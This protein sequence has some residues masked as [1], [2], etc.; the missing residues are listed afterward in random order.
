MC[1]SFVAFLSVYIGYFYIQLFAVKATIGSPNFSANFVTLLNVGSIPGRLGSNFI[2]GHIGP[3]N[4]QI[5]VSVLT[6]VMMYAWMGVHNTGGLIVFAIFYGAFTGGMMSIL[7]PVTVALSPD[8]RN[9]GT[10]MGMVTFVT[11]IAVLVG[12][13]IAG[14][15][16]K[17]YSRTCWLHM[18]GYAGGTL[19]LASVFF[20]LTK[21]KQ[22]K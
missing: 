15:I 20:I 18:M 12:P 3:L 1:G 4:T 5:A 11:G 21:M 6:A 8:L 13:P 22:H 7:A 10:R 17:D 14:A 9:L 2:A 19:S 16:L